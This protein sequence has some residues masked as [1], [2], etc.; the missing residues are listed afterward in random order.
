MRHKAAVCLS[1]AFCFL[2]SSFPTMGKK[3]QGRGHSGGS[4]YCQAKNAS[5]VL[6]SPK[7]L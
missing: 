1:V 7:A 4:R 6:A 3:M 5:V 2:A